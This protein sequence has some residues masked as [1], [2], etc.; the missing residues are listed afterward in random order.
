LASP[1]AVDVTQR[2]SIVMRLI[3]SLLGTL[4]ALATTATSCLAGAL[5]EI[6][7]ADPN[8]KPLPAYLARP[9]GAGPFPAVVV[10]HGCNGFGSLVVGWADRLARWGYVALAI[11]SLTPH[12]ATVDGA[13]AGGSLQQPVDAYRGLKFLAA[14]P[15]VRADRI[16][17]L[18]AS[19]GGRS[20]LTAF[21][22]GLIE[23]MFAHKFRSGVAFYPGCEGASGLM[24]APTLV[25]V[26]ELDDW[27]PAAPCRDMVDGKNA[28]GT[29]RQ[30]GDR[31]M[32]ELVIYPDAYHSFDAAGLPSGYRYLGH[33]MQYNEAATQDAIN[34]VHSFFERTLGN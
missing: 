25:L 29:P 23:P 1:Q 22:R 33:R 27:T 15:F 10:L 24:M 8:E 31:S 16:A 5:I 11:D 19:M 12:G 14:Q 2:W 32:V 4:I 17:V 28:I 26:G 3:R 6:P 13:C 30:P 20:V 18:G 34:R 9:P 21:E 7:G